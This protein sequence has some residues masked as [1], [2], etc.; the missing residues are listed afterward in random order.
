MFPSSPVKKEDNVKVKIPRRKPV[1][2]EFV[3][4]TKKAKSVFL[5]EQKATEN[6]VCSVSPQKSRHTCESEEIFLSTQS[7]NPRI[8]IPTE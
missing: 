2:E 1:R 6:K 8:A 3:T 5:K 7:P 4:K